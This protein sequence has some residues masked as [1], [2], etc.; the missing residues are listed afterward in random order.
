MTELEKKAVR[1]ERKLRGIQVVVFLVVFLLPMNKGNPNWAVILFVS[2]SVLSIMVGGTVEPANYLGWL[3]VLLY[4]WI[5]PILFVLNLIL[6]FRPSRVARVVSRTLAPILLIVSC[7]YGLRSE[8]V[9]RGV[10]FWAMYSV[11][12]I[13]VFVEVVL[14]LSERR[15]RNQG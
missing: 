5:T 1:I 2:H 12:F 13:Y 10:G 15:A 8:P 14:A 9:W 4:F 6:L 11:P 7:Y 3:G